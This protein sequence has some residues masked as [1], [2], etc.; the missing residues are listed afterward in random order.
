MATIHTGNALSILRRQ[1]DGTWVVA[2][3]A[4]LLTVKS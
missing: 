3:D 2:R 4:D 1:A